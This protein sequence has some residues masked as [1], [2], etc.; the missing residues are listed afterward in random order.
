MSKQLIIRNEEGGAAIEMSIALPVLVMFI[1]GIFQVGLVF[2][3]NAG[4]Q[5]ALG[6]AAREA[7]IHPVPSDVD[8]AEIIHDKRFGTHNGTLAAAKFVTNTDEDGDPDGSR[9]LTLTYSQPTD[10]LFIE[11]PTFAV[12]KSKTFYTAIG[13]DTPG[14]TTCDFDE[15]GDMA[16]SSES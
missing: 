10:L 6:E 2:Q 3:A 9:T 16:C 7:T 14:T 4:V 15:D 12:T 13:N 8:L 5:H 11:G 1:Y